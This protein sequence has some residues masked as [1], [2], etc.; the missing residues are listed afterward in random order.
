MTTTATLLLSFIQSATEFLP[1]SSSGHLILTEKF[2]FSNQNLL[3]DIS[4]HLGTLFAVCAFFFK[5]I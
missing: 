4:L 1:V 2:G 3:T 5:D